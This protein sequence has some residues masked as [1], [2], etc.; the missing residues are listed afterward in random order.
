MNQVTITEILDDLRAADEMTRRYERRYW[1]SSADFHDLY[2]QGLLDD[3]E[4]LEDFTLG[5][6]FYQI[7]IRREADL[8][9]LSQRRLEQLSSHD[10]KI[11]LDKG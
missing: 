4:N 2:Q 10:Q 9:N 6:S 11:H 8:Q 1:L 3:G 7:K 5:A